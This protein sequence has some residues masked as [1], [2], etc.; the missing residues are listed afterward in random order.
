MYFRSDVDILLSGRRTLSRVSFK[1]SV[2]FL[3]LALILLAGALSLSYYYLDNQ[4]R[5]TAAGDLKG[6]MDSAQ[7]AER[8]NPF[9]PDPLEAESYILQ[10]QG[11]DKEAADALQQAIDRDPNN[12]ATYLFLGNLQMYNL[13]DLNAADTNYRKSLRLNPKATAATQG[14][15]QAL[16]RQGDLKGSKKQYEILQEEKGISPQG[17]YDLGRIYVR[18]SEPVKGEQTIKLARRRLLGQLKTMQASQ[19]TQAEDL[20]RS[21]TLA[22]ADALVVQGEYDRARMILVSSDAQQAPA[23]LE[24]LNS[25][26]ERYRQSVLNSA[27]Y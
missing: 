7:R 25:D 17:L 18:T 20:L 6:A 3:L 11:R 5:L 27:I 1:I 16:L 23:I 4:V 26:P 8:L 10:Q 21:M 24:L 2:G 15:A 13:D 14:L 19:K 22:I 12:Y 9:S